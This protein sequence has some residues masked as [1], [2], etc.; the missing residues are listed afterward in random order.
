MYAIRSYYGLD[1]GVITKVLGNDLSCVARRAHSNV[2]HGM[3]KL[4]HQMLKNGF[5]GRGGLYGV[6][7]ALTMSYN[8]V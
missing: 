2:Q 7:A 8:F 5:Y 1:V 4:T 3:H 6:A